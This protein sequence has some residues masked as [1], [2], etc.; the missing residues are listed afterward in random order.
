VSK[1][2]LAGTGGVAWCDDRKLHKGF[3]IGYTL[4]LQAE[5]TTLEVPLK[6][7]ESKGWRQLQIYTDSDMLTFEE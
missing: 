4:S 2:K 3:Q 7:A 6:M 5:A 1:S